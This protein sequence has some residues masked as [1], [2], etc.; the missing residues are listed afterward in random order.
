MAASIDMSLTLT[1]SRHG[2]WL[3]FLEENGIACKFGSIMVYPETRLVI[4][5][6]ATPGHIC[7]RCG[8]NEFSRDYARLLALMSTSHA[9]DAMHSQRLNFNPKYHLFTINTYHS[10]SSNTK[11][12][13]S[14][15]PPTT[16]NTFF[17][18][19]LLCRTRND[20]RS[21]G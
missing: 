10:K 13:A 16:C 7:G 1:I 12:Q 15:I 8:P 5:F 17:F 14:R 18:K 21:M 19:I 11:S 9:C 4:I 3:E 20:G 2:L 6:L